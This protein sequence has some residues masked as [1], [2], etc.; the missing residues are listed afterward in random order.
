MVEILSMIK[1]THT[2]IDTFFRSK[3]FLFFPSLLGPFKTG[4]I[5]FNIKCSACA[6]C[7]ARKE[8]KRKHRQKFNVWLQN[9]ISRGA[10]KYFVGYS[11]ILT[12]K[13]ILT[14]IFFST[15]RRFS[16]YCHGIVRAPWTSTMGWKHDEE[17]TICDRRTYAR[18]IYFSFNY[19]VAQ[20]NF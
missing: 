19:K 20:Y 16:R 12:F 13:D 3:Y 10:C 17:Q 7:Q 18:G 4:N 15:G 6:F 5:Q 14:F 1:N 11:N 9:S 8:G 2:S